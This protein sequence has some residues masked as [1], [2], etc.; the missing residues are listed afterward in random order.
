MGTTKATP[1]RALELRASGLKVN[2]VATALGVSRR[3]AMR[4]LSG[5]R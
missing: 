1:D 2:E 4:Y 5:R 3:T